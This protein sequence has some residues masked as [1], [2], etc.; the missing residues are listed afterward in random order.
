MRI[1]RPTLEMFCF[2]RSMP[3]ASQMVAKNSGT[4]TGRSLSATPSAGL[5]GGAGRRN[6]RWPRPF[7][8]PGP[9]G[10]G[11]KWA[12]EYPAEVL[13]N[14]NKAQQDL[15]RGFGQGEPGVDVLRVIGVQ[16][17]ALRA[18]DAYLDARFEVNQ[19]LANLAATVGDPALAVGCYGMAPSAET[20]MDPQG[21]GLPA[22][23]V[24]P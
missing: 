5:S 18:A 12:Q 3:R 4:V 8:R 2:W 17:N 19:A 16:R 22:S 24:R 7:R 10:G 21:R 14:L 9:S 1:G 23:P 20:P 13:P 6:F 11:R 15:E